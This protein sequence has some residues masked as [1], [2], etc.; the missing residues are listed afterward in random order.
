MVTILLVQ[1]WDH[2]REQ[3]LSTL[4]NE[5][6]LSWVLVPEEKYYHSRAT[7]RSRSWVI[8]PGTRKYYRALDFVLG[9]VVLFEYLARDSV[10]DEY[11]TYCK[12]GLI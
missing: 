9:L 4:D 2:V 1:Y 12:L 8:V 10:L 11:Y 7:K 3:V 6:M 5:E